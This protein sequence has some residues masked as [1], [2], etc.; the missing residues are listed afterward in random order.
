MKRQSETNLFNISRF[1]KAM[2]IVVHENKA[3][4]PES[5]SLLSPH[6]K[7]LHELMLVSPITPLRVVTAAGGIVRRQV[8]VCDPK[9]RHRGGQSLAWKLEAVTGQVWHLEQAA[10]TLR[11]PPRF[12]LGFHLTQ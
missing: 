1:R 9:S 7:S 6:A 5:L 8:V 10:S 11:F 2:S 12:L 3:V 4:L